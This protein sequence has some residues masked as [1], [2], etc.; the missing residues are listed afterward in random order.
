MVKGLARLACLLL[1]LPAVAT[2]AVAAAG[3]ARAQ[4]PNI[5]LV[6]ADDLDAATPLQYFPNITK[7]LVQQ[8][9]S[10]ERFFVTNSW[11]C[12]SRSSIL[13]SQYVHSHGVLTN[14]GPEGGFEKFYRTSL[15]RSTIGT[16]MQ[17]AGYRTAL[18][19][20]YL[21]HYPDK[22]TAPTYVPPGWND[23]QVPV[24]N[25]YEEYGY[26]LN[27]NGKLV[28]HGWAAEDYLS[29]VLAVKAR[30]FIN[31][32]TNPFFLYLA[33][34]AP[35]NP[36]NPA[37][38]HA[39]AFPEATAPRS[40]SFNQAN[41]D[42]EPLWLRSLPKIHGKGIER[43]DERY[44]N[45]LRAM[46]GVDDLVGSVMSTLQAS[47]KLNNT[48]VFFASDNGFHLGTHRLKQGKT[49]PFE[50]SI[51]VPL[52]VRGPGI[53]PNSVIKPMA[54]TVDLSPTFAALAGAAV[55][56]FAEGRSLLPVLRGETPERWRHNALIEFY[57]PTDQMSARQTPVPNY[58]AL[59]TD[60]YTYVQYVTGEIQLYDL[61]QDPYQLTNIATTAPPGLL[62]RL[63][64]R[65]TM[66]RTCSG[67][68]CLVADMLQN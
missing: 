39:A 5:V 46:L 24:T 1:L 38:R 68:S 11:C 52:V 66:M 16:W 55:P 63:N 47:G 58:S 25:L 17:S 64:T 8:G 54:A 35:H 40:P 22:V 28:D 9:A 14:T 3:E 15:E 41:V 4:R 13:R 45:R 59:R 56:T 21:N 53:A 65:L 26:R 51:R 10:F 6:L 2:P 23:W 60:E 30:D 20:K 29:D 7:Q 48:Y 32:S 62:W 50:E 12:P 67:Q 44:R 33:P 19:G 43:I 61:A 37:V 31:A 57:R 36:A 34:V 27:E 18:M 49:T 42:K